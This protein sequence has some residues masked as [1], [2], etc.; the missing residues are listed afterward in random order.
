MSF[1]DAWRALC[2]AG[3][4]TLMT[5][6]SINA[7]LDARMVA[8]RTQGLCTAAMFPEQSEFPILH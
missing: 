4:A 3:N 7:M 5:V 6:P 2:K 8:I 1:A